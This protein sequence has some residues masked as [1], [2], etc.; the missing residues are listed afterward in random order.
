MSLSWFF[1]DADKR[2]IED[3]V[4][5]IEAR[6]SARIVVSARRISGDYRHADY[7]GGAA[8]AL[9][10]LAGF[11][12]H[13]EPFDY[14]YFPVE[15]A[16]AFA[17]GALATNAIDPVRKLFLSASSM[18]RIVAT[19]AR[20]AFVELGVGT[21]EE[22]S[23]VL[24]FVSTFEG[25]LEVVSD[26]GIDPAALGAAWSDAIKKLERAVRRDRDPERFIA[27]LEELGA[28]LV[29]AFP[30]AKDEGAEEEEDASPDS[31]GEGT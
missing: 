25:A 15:Q 8:V 4:A 20:A 5:K 18:R 6:T 13:P 24:V 30:S 27:A 26:V 9:A 31:E 29:T 2:R 10:L 19:Q 11:L 14:T 3:A 21:S 22:R 16:A 17:V 23:G 7:L 28:C 1:E 12:Y